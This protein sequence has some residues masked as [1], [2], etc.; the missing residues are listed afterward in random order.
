MKKRFVSL[1][2]TAV[3]C[4]SL[5]ACGSTANTSEATTSS[6]ETENEVE[7]AETTDPNEEEANADS[8]VE[9]LNI[10]FAIMEYPDEPQDIWMKTFVEKVDELS[11]G[12]I[13][14]ETHYCG[15]LGDGSD[16]IELIQSNVINMGT[17]DSGP[18]AVLI[19]EVGVL[20]LHWMM[21]ETYDDMYNFLENAES[22]Q[23][24]DGLFADAG[25]EVV[26]WETEGANF[27]TADRPLETP[28]D[29]VG[30]NMRTMENPLIEASYKAYGANATVISF[31]ELYSALQLGTV[32]GEINPASVIY[33]S[34]FYE[35][36]DY[37]IQPVADYNFYSVVVNSDFYAGLT[38]AQ[39]AVI[40]EAIAEASADYREKVEQNEADSLDTLV[41]ECGMTLITLTEE[42][43]QALKELSGSVQEEYVQIAGG[44][45]QEIL[46]QFIVDL[47]TLE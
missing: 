27:W 15:E 36:Q 16:Q 10:V 37:L 46:D 38:D 24:I 33:S 8:T 7:E 34:K 21:P 14:V 5:I 44:K 1:L 28:E 39:K 23:M 29:F 22:I 13:T 43:R 42:Q 35:V 26:T 4:V 12:A 25:L 40:E 32:D 2:L 18:A 11:G 19:P 45:S 9:P 6:A 20:A 17:V 47:E 3:M 30:F 31:S 41:N